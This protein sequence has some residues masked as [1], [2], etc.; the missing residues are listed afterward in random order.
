M[1]RLCRRIESGWSVP[2]TPRQISDTT[3]LLLHSPRYAY[4]LF[5]LTG[6]TL[7]L[8]RA[9]TNLRE[10]RGNLLSGELQHYACVTAAPIILSW[11]HEKTCTAWC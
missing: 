10:T 8:E 11:S 7:R 2:A 6:S 4:P 1:I 5:N 9:A 3:W